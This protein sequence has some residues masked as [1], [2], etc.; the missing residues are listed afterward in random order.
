MLCG[1][2][3]DPPPFDLSMACRIAAYIAL[4]YVAGFFILVVPSGLGVREYFLLLCLAPELNRFLPAGE[5]AAVA[6]VLVLMLRLVWTLA[7][8]VM[9]AL[10]YW[11]PVESVAA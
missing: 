5:A 11:L 8:L 7:D 9:T 3:P 4:A 6:A 2:M 1:L 10:V